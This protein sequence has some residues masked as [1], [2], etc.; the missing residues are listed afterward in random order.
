MITCTT[1]AQVG[2]LKG[3][4]TVKAPAIAMNPSVIAISAIA[5]PTRNATPLGPG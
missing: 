4:G 1:P 2:G 3:C 5:Q